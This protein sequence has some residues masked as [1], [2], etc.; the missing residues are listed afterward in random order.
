MAATKNMKHTTAVF[1]IIAS[2]I[3]PGMPVFAQGMMAP[4]AA[5]GADDDHT[6]AEEAAGKI[7]WEKLAAKETT[8]ADLASGEFSSLG[9]YFMGLMMGS[10]H[11]AM[12]SMMTA[13]MGEEGEEQMHI[14]MGKRISG[15][16]P[17]AAVPA[18]GIGYMPM[19]QMMW[20]ARQQDGQGWP[21][22][23]TGGYGRM[24]GFSSG[25]LGWVAFVGIILW[26]LWWIAIVAAIVILARWII[27]KIRGEQSASALDILKARYAKGEIGKTEF[28]EMKRT[29]NL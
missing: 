4:A 1:F 8:C 13:M 19:M 6:A 15:C 27:R 21:Y 17:S 18:Q 24:I 29:I 22:S 10:S 12:N 5:N 2:L 16:D 3:A 14:A 28:E 20:G 11:E 9:E 7:V 26:L 23:S 25:A